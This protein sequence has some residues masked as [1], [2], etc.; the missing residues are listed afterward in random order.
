MRRTAADRRS[1]THSSRAA[2]NATPP[3]Q[4]TAATAGQFSRRYHGATAG[5]DAMV[6]GVAAEG[7][8]PTDRGADGC[9]AA[10][11]RHC[12]AGAVHIDATC[13]GPTV[14]GA[15][16]SGAAWSTSPEFDLAAGHWAASV[17][18]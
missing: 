7:R 12:A 1:V 9:V 4:T 14:A 18:V 17:G 5:G 16:S 15:A 8:V 13:T 2:T 10:D 6:A 11:S 3:T